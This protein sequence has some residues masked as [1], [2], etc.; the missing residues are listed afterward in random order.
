MSLPYGEK[1]VVHSEPNR[2]ELRRGRTRTAPSNLSSPQ[3]R[4]RPTTVAFPP[5]PREPYH[6]MITTAEPWR[7]YLNS[8]HIIPKLPPSTTSLHPPLQNLHIT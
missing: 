5:K 8:L 6:V 1:Y 3:A 4:R 7:Q 2:L